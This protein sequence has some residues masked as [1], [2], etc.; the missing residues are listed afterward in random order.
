MTIT[1]YSKDILFDVDAETH[2]F[3]RS[4][5]QKNAELVDNMAS[6]SAEGFDKQVLIRYANLAD[7]EVRKVMWKF[8]KKAATPATTGND[9]L[10][11]SITSYVYALSVSDRRLT[12]KLPALTQAIHGYLV[13][14]ILTNF[15]IALHQDGGAKNYLAKTQQSQLDIEELIYKRDKP[16][17]EVSGG[18]V[19]GT[20]MKAW[21]NSDG[22]T[23]SIVFT[24]DS[25]PTSSSTFYYGDWS[26]VDCTVSVST[27]PSGLVVI[28]SV[29]G[30]AKAYLRD[31]AHDMVM[32]D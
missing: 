29:G 5:D 16:S 22:D 1:I 17:Y 3:A 31:S 15:F 10:D 2:R 11:T 23:D 20:Q 12:N 8:L 32:P 13:N 25:T 24:A 6:D 26:Q 21:K 19:P 28:L 4:L 27:I 18:A 14:S 9:T 30:T 7:A